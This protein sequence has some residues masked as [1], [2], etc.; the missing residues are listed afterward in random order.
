[1]M[2]G[3]ICLKNIGC[4]Q[5]DDYSDELVVFMSC[6]RYANTINYVQVIVF[7]FF[8]EIPTLYNLSHV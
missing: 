6:L 7:I 3:Y 4:D 1:M 5:D 8:Y 2:I